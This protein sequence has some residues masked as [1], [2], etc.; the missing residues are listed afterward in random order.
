MSVMT[1]LSSDYNWVVS[2]HLE[3]QSCICIHRGTT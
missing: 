2:H 1:E 3:I